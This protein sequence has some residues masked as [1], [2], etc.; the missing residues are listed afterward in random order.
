MTDR[1]GVALGHEYFS[2]TMIR[3]SVLSVRLKGLE[4]FSKVREMLTFFKYQFHTHNPKVLLPYSG[5]IE[6][7]SAEFSVWEVKTYIETR[8]GFDIEVMGLVNVSGDK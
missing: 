2:I 6:G 5:S 8:L 7:L 1:L 3:R 4:S